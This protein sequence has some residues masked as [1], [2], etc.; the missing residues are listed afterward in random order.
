MN[1]LAII[2]SSERWEY[3]VAWKK[4]FDFQA[5]AKEEIGNSSPLA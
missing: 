4:M 2:L 1:F 5:K 3:Q